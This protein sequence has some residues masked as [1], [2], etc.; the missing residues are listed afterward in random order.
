M[1]RNRLAA[2]AAA[3]LAALL[4]AA[5]PGAAQVPKTP[6]PP[7]VPQLPDSVREMLRELQQLR[8]DL[9]SI[10]E[11]TLAARA[12]LRA[13]REA[14]QE[15]VEAAMVA[16]HPGIEQTLRRLEGLGAELRRAHA[17]NDTAR[18][19]Q[20]LLDGQRMQQAVQA[21][22]SEAMRREDVAR[23]VQTYQDHLLAAMKLEDPRT[24]HLLVRLE[25]LARRLEAAR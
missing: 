19:R 8:R 11:K 16:A 15:A 4:A 20:I 21:A 12:E 14:A 9:A 5:A 13:E 1:T 23:K 3:V 18:M 24:E 6:L 25:E 2:G 7:L 22:Q 17:Q 10:Q